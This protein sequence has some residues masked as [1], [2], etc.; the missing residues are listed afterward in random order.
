M[1]DSGNEIPECEGDRGGK[2]VSLPA[3]TSAR[4]QA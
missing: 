4:T 1:K 2:K 3:N